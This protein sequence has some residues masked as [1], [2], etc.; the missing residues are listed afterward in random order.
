MAT[1]GNGNGNELK[2]KYVTAEITAH[3]SDGSTV[4]IGTVALG[5]KVFHTGSVG[6]WAQAGN[7]RIAGIPDKDYTLQ[8]QLVQNAS[9]PEG[10]TAKKRA[11]EMAKLHAAQN[12]GQ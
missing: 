11:L 5:Y 9:N 10:K 1:A 7:V 6:F 2:V 12:A 8:A 4:N 3:M